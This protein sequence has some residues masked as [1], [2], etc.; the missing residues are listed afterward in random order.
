MPT[1]SSARAALASSNKHFLP[2][3]STL[4]R[5]LSPLAVRQRTS[6]PQLPL[7]APVETSYQAN[8]KL[9]MSVL[10]QPCAKALPRNA[11]HASSSRNFLTYSSIFRRV[12]APSAVRQRTPIQQLPSPAPVGTFYYFPDTQTCHSST[13]RS[14]TQSRT[15]SPIC[16]SYHTSRNLDV[17]YLHQP[18]DNAL[19]RNAA[20]S[21]SSRNFL[22]YSSIFRR[23]NAPSAVRPR[24]PIQQ[25]PSPA[26][27]GTFYYFPDT[28]T[29]HSSTIRSL[30]QSRT[31]APICTSYHTSRNLDVSYLHQPCDNALPRNAAHASSS[32][33]FLT[34]SS[35]FRRVNAPSAVRQRTPIQQLPS[36]APVGT[37]YYFP[38]TQ[39]CHSSTI[40]SITQSRT[41]API[42]TSPCSISRAPAHSYTAT[43]LA[44]SSRYFLLFP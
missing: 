29:C 24:T 1:H 7:P 30:T 17:S 9:D 6:K 16:T 26:P 37:F 25:M 22:T 20:H 18:C 43:A 40:R 12:N 2:N 36:P 14:L 5:A 44:S 32:R 11:A 4:R 8:R 27:V 42:C 19:P 31:T 21:S 10:H 38:D 13:T 39:T 35:I 23:V 33:N 15:T 34:Y 3:S 28:Q 41:T